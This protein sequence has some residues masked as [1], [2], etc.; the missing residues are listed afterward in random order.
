MNY[1]VNA[2]RVHKR[3]CGDYSA[4]V[5]RQKHNWNLERHEQACKAA[6]AFLKQHCLIITYGKGP[7]KAGDAVPAVEEVIGREPSDRGGTRLHLCFVQPV[8]P[9][10]VACH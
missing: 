10:L 5:N 2:W 4:A 1:D 7:T 8:C 9:E 3:T 6:D